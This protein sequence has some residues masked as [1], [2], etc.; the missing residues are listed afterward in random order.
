[1]EA[2]RSTASEIPEGETLWT[3]VRGARRDM[4]RL[5]RAMHACGRG[6]SRFPDPVTTRLAHVDAVTARYL[7][8]GAPRLDV[9]VRLA[10]A[11]MRSLEQ[12]IVDHLGADARAEVRR[13]AI[14]VRIDEQDLAH[15]LLRTD[16]TGEDAIDYVDHAGTDVRSLAAG[17]ASLG[18]AQLVAVCRRLGLQMAGAEAPDPEARAQ[19]EQAVLKTLLDGHLLAILIATLSTEAHE[20]LAALV[21]DEVDDATAR[22]LAATLAPAPDAPDAAVDA[23]ADL[24]GAP[25]EALAACALVFADEGRVWV[26][27]ELHRRVDGVLRAFGI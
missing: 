20:L 25:A 12:W 10:A 11:S 13:R 16:W 4:A 27:P 18:D 8:E 15:P 26:A 6:I 23:P 24:D 9:E 17:I 21:R 3:E 14:G 19:A 5:L 7:I 2:S 22:A 1:M